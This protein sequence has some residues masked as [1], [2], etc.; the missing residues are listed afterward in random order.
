RGG[1][2]REGRRAHHCSTRPPPRQTG[3]QAR[4]KLIGRPTAPTTWSTDAAPTAPRSPS[5][6]ERPA[7]RT[8]LEPFHRSP[9][10]ANGLRLARPSEPFHR[11]PRPAAGL[12]LALF[13]HFTARL[14]RRP[15]CGS[16]DPR[17]ISP[18]ASAGGRPQLEPFAHFT[19]RL[20]RPPDR[21]RTYP[22]IHR[23]TT[24]HKQ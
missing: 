21:P 2:I 19:R 17:A 18:L 6:V 16:H 4:W 14:G 13:D 7:A 23:S 10:P 22:P 24:P 5:A 1:G 3:A 12:R 8:T 11:S 9:R 20:G 15:A